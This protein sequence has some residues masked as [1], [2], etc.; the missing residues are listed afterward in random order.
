[1]LL[2]IWQ[3]TWIKQVHMMTSLYVKMYLNRNGSFKDDMKWKSRWHEFF[4]LNACYCSYREW[5]IFSIFFWPCKCF[6]SIFNRLLSCY[7]WWS[8]H[9]SL[10]DRTKSPLYFVLLFL[11]NN[12]Q[13]YVTISERSVPASIIL[14]FK[15]C[16]SV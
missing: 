8:N 4:F 11:F 14:W 13:M 3:P 2:N 1:M 9:F 7:V 10:L 15:K 6:N 16:M 12:Y 5:L